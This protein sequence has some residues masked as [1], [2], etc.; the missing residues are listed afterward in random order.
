MK[1]HF[2]TITA[3]ESWENSSSNREFTSLYKHFHL[4]IKIL[5]IALIV[6]MKL[7]GN[8]AGYPHF[9]CRNYCVLLDR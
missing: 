9:K 6:E 1:L 8:I 4:Y 7:V 2:A 5:I 3:R